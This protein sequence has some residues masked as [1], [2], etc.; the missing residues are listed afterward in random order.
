MY[1]DNQKNEFVTL[2]AEGLSFD[3]ISEKLK[4]NKK[5]LIRWNKDKINEINS[6]KESAFE[7]M[8]ESLQVS[9]QNRVKMLA[10]ELNKINSALTDRSYKNYRVT[11]LLNYKMKVISELSKFDSDFKS[12]L[13]KDTEECKLDDI[14][15][16][17]PDDG[18]IACKSLKDLKEVMKDTIETEKQIMLEF[19]NKDNDDDADDD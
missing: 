9:T 15:N 16:L 11:E 1:T 10:D 6:L 3:K 17:Q 5:T 18:L 13:K 4:I 2:R 14:S 19:N 7:S 12:F 8:M